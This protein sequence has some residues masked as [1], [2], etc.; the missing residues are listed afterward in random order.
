VDH[1][2]EMCA[3]IIRILKPGGHFI[4]SFNLEE[5]VSKCEPQRLDEAIIAQHLLRHLNVESYRITTKGPENDF[6]APFFNK[7]LS[8]APG[9]EGFLWVK[10]RK[11]G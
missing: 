2:P 3:E 6:Y 9:Q 10:A 11:P 5:P 8:Y 1:F 4:G 7:A